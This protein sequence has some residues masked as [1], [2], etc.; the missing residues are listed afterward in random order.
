MACVPMQSAGHKASLYVPGGNR[1]EQYN[2]MT[3]EMIVVLVILGGA[4]VLFASATGSVSTSSR[5]W[6]CS[7]SC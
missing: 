7:R 6:L 4:I 5:S 3:G 2:T 1:N